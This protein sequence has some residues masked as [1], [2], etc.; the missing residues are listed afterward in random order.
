MKKLITIMI[1][2]AIMAS[3]PLAFARDES[4]DYL[5]HIWKQQLANQKRWEAVVNAPTPS[6]RAEALQTYQYN[7]PQLWEPRP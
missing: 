2:L 3:A 7:L 1:S 4:R 6:E 5:M